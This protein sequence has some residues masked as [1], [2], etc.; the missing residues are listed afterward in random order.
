MFLMFLPKILQFRAVRRQAKRP[1]LA[2]AALALLVLCIAIAAPARADSR[3]GE[4][5]AKV[6]P[7]TL[8]PGADKFGPIEGSPPAVA[9]YKGGKLAG[10]VFI[11]S[12]YAD[13]TGYSGKPIEILLGMDL[14]GTITGAKLV[15]HH[16]PIVLIGIPEKR[17]TDFIGGYVGTNI[18]HPGTTTVDDT[19]RGP[20]HRGR[21]RGG[22]AAAPEDTASSVAVISG[23]TVTV[24]IISDSI[25]R[26]SQ[27]LAESRGIGGLRPKRGARAAAPTATV[28]MARTQTED[29]AA[30]LGDGSV[31]RLHLS[32][33]EVNDAFVRSGNKAAADRPEHGDP[34]ATFID[35]YVTLVSVPAIGHSLLGSDIYG[36]LTKS[37][38]PGQQVLLIAGEGRYSFKGSGYVRGGIFDRIR[39]IQGE[40]T[41]RFRDHDYRRIG[42]L[43][44]GG[45]PQ[46]PEIGLFTV[47]AE[48][49][50]DPVQPWRLQVLVQRQ[51]G[52]LDK[53]FLNFDLGY[54]L[55]NKYLKPV[56]A[57]KP[58]AT[59]QPVPAPQPQLQNG[60]K[61]PAVPLWQR[62]WEQRKVEIVIIVVALG[63]L[64]FIF[65]FQNLIVQRPRLTKG[66][67]VAFL[68]FTVVWIG[69]Y[70][71]AQLSVVNVVTFSHALLGGFRWDLFLLEPVIFILW[72]SVA[73]SLLFWGRG[74]Y[75][76]WLCPFGALQE[77]LNN[78][79]KLVGIPQVKL[80]WGL[81]ERLWPI[82]YI[83][84]LVIF[85]ISLHSLGDAERVAE[86][87]PFKTV[88]VLRF[89]RD[90]PYVLYAGLLLGIGLFI[91]RFF[92]RYLCPLGAA[93]ALPGRLR[94][95]DWLK[96]HKECGSPCQICSRECMVQAIHPQGQINPNECLYCLHCQTLYYD[97]H[98]CP[99]MIQRRLKKERWLAL[100]SDSML[101][102]KARQRKE[103]VKGPARA[104][105]TTGN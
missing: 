9:A 85:G 60:A 14:S 66:L 87:E 76:G 1:F 22:T 50:L 45:A 86:I 46:L 65:F 11:N 40:R 3:L 71:Q 72:F 96:R 7:S 70:A 93:L 83:A 10:Y 6:P 54:R 33:G 17:V 82:K 90:W 77:L 80:P 23:A 48:S 81:H 104:P 8:F 49:P 97:K 103:T 42:E 19:S 28:D 95:F 53:A 59:A 31:R 74:A 44:A 37:L 64:T 55:P 32:V 34:Q 89:M 12:D 69:G 88:V 101:S 99:P 2:M 4:F 68:I 21:N 38:K 73:A 75:C 29:W 15:E 78:A 94:M 84:F 47:P 58:V 35:L 79:A 91:E 24:M 20:R 98:R 67:R 57:P 61:A 39:V 26:A 43:A 30:L 25:S 100:Q 13:A 18:L 41:I 36:Q 105:A 52:A 5:L 51:I 56:A 102:D 92:C 27:A 63:F 16:E 62:I